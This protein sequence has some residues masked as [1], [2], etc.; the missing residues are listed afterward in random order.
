[1]SKEL[2]GG[3]KIKLL[4]YSLYR[5]YSNGKYRATTDYSDFDIEKAI[6]MHEGDSLPGFPSVDVFHYL[7][8]P[9]LEKIREPAFECVHEVYLYLE[10]LAESIAN[11]VFSRFPSIISEIMEIV[12]TILQQVGAYY[13]NF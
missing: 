8:Q 5:D 9:Q 4:F 6:I 7:I 3:A 13:P 2:T 12:S 11:K 1:M 10:S